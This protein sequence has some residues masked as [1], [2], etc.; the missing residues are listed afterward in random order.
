MR[1]A[2][3]YEK[4]HSLVN[5]EYVWRKHRPVDQLPLVDRGPVVDDAEEARHKVVDA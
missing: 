3:L 1:S 4:S 5:C 2:V